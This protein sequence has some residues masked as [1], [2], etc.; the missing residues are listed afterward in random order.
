MSKVVA[1][2]PARAGSK[3]I[4]NKN[5]YPLNGKPLIEWTITKAKKVDE[6]DRVLVSTDG[7]KIAD[8]SKELGAEVLRRSKRL[9]MDQSLI[10]E[11]IRDVIKKLE[12]DNYFFDFLLLL[13]PT[14]PLRSCQD[15]KSVIS[16]LNNGFDSVATF[17]HARLNPHRAWKISKSMPLAFIPDANPWLPRQ[18]LPEAWE[19]NGAVYG[20][21][22]SRLREYE[23]T[24]LLFGKMK[25]V[26]MPE[27]RSV[28]IDNLQDLRIVEYIMKREWAENEHCR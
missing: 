8:F 6:I 21:N 7:D 15:I 27:D 16:E 18:K 10:I 19:L 26:L 17:T 11:T 1:L 24:A 14:S 13:E 25:A 9:S 28:D 3:G 20:F 23:G 12:K 5:L 22:V 4:K 2:I